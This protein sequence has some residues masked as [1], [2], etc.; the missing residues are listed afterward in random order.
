MPSRSQLWNCNSVS[1][2]RTYSKFGKFYSVCSDC[3]SLRYVTVFMETVL[4]CIVGQRLNERKQCW[5]HLYIFTLLFLPEWWGFY[6]SLQVQ[7]ELHWM[8]E[9]FS[10]FPSAKRVFEC[11]YLSFSA[12][13][14]TCLSGRP[15]GCIPVNLSPPLWDWRALTWDRAYLGIFNFFFLNLKRNL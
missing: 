5:F 8:H 7:F 1:F 4:G 13:D 9:W 12:P 3:R 14:S 6:L 10:T 2:R 15:S 11:V